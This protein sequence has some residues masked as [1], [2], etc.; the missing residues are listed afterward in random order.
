[1]LKLYYVS[2]ENLGDDY[3]YFVR[4]DSANDAMVLWYSYAFSK[5]LA[6][7][8]ILQELED[9]YWDWRIFRITDTRPNVARVLEW[10]GE[11]ANVTDE[12]KP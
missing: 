3:S 7:E 9:D 4:A 2:A 5:D 1:M 12:V 11:V 6:L 10:Y 8:D